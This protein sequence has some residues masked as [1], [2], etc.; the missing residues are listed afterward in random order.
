MRLDSDKLAAI[1]KIDNKH[2][3]DFDNQAI[4]NNQEVM[5]SNVNP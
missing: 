4:E 3:F 1:E 5:K 2:D